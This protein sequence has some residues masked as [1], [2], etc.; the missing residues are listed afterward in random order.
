M[1]ERW[2]LGMLLL[3]TAWV[4][5]DSQP[6]QGAPSGQPTEEELI[7]DEKPNMYDRQQ[8]RERQMYNQDDNFGGSG[9]YYYNQG[10][11]G[12][13]SSYYYNSPAPMQSGSQS[14]RYK[15]SYQN[16]DDATPGR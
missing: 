6:Q 1:K 15:S 9:N 10:S 14:Y 7:A 16:Y 12:S 2:M 13:S 5:A 4:H 3:G 8:I 11:S